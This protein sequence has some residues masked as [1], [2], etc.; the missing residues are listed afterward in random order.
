MG[1]TLAAKLA[2][3]E[4]IKAQSSFTNSHVKLAS[5]FMDLGDVVSAM[6]QYEVA[7]AANP[8]DPDI[9]YQRGQGKQEPSV[10][11]TQR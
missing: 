6:K 8:K 7:I 1:D 11:T 4:S 3:E 5:V 10:V 9:Y 2:L